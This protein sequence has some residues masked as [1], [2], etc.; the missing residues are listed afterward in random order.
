M[1]DRLSVHV[2]RAVLKL[3]KLQ[4]TLWAHMEKIAVLGISLDMNKSTV[5]TG[6][7]IG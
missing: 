2:L 4:A 7:V 5:C 1:T 6:V 3:L